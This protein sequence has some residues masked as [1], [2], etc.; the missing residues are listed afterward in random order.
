SGTPQYYHF[1]LSRWDDSETPAEI[2]DSITLLRPS[3]SDRSLDQLFINQT[4]IPKDHWQYDAHDRKLIW[5]KAFGGGMLTLWRNGRGAA[6]IVGDSLPL[7]PVKATAATQYICDVTLDCGGS[8]NSDGTNVLDITWDPN[9]D[10]WE[11][12]TWIADRLVIS[13]ISVDNGP[14]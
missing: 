10:A 2:P 12:A 8:R 3:L 9:S 14:L 7:T 6:G 5:K 13:Y 11:K 1:K 4:P